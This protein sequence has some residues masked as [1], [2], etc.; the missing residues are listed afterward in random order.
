MKICKVLFSALISVVMADTMADTVNSPTVDMKIEESLQWDNY[1]A[2]I[3]LAVLA[4]IAALF[5][6]LIITCVQM[7]HNEGLRSDEVPH[8]NNRRISVRRRSY[9][10]TDLD[11]LEEI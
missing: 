9:A 11:I 3:T 10:P 7:V 4:V 8:M 1:P 2:T 5:I 6:I